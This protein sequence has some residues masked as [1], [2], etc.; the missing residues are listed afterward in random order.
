VIVIDASAIIELLR[1]TE[2]GA[3]VQHLVE[4]P[5]QTL[6]APHLI[7]VEIA[8]TLRRLAAS[9]VISQR[10]AAQR[11]ALLAGLDL[12]RYPHTDLLPRIWDLRHNVTAYDAVYLALSEVLSATLL[13][14]D[15]ALV[16]VPGCDADVR[17]V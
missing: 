1:R 14:C 4:D 16:D 6:H 2:A 10:T 12:H 15:A 17:C 3:R 5:D 13:T 8:S 7:D 9:Q 11:L